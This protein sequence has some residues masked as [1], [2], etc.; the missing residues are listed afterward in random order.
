MTAPK[1]VVLFLGLPYTGKSTLIR[2]LKRELPGEEIIADAIFLD[3]VAPEEV[4]LEAWL[5]HGPAL[6]RRIEQAIAASPASLCYVELGIMRARD[7]SDLSEWILGQGH[8]SIPVWLRCEDGQVLSR[9]RSA[10]ADAVGGQTGDGVDRGEGP[11]PRTKPS[12]GLID[13]DLDGLY[14][15]I[16]AA[17]EEPRADE[18]Y[19]IIDTEGDVVE[20]TSALSRIIEND[21]KA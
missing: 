16:R 6:V 15:R 9:R 8:R 11:A 21:T 1:T 12:E 19:R 2:E 13:I 10:R 4:S 5:A 7:R 18:G 20:C 17:F 14:Q 3:E